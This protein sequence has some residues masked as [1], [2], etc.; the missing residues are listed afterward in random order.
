MSEFPSILDLSGKVSFKDQLA[1][2]DLSQG[3]FE[4]L[5]LNTLQQLLTAIINLQTPSP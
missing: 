2:I 4:T 3:S 1:H 5:V